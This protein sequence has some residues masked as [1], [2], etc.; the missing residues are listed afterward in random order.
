MLICATERLL[1]LCACC[2]RGNANRRSS[3]KI[4]SWGTM[5]GSNRTTSTSSACCTSRGAR[6]CRFSS[7]AA[8]SFRDV[9]TSGRK[10]RKMGL[11]RCRARIRVRRAL[12]LV[13]RRRLPL[14]MNSRRC[15]KRIKEKLVARH[16]SSSNDDSTLPGNGSRSRW[17]YL[18]V[19]L[20]QSEWR[21]R[22]KATNG[23]CIVLGGKH[24]R[25]SNLPSRCQTTILVIR[26]AGYVL[27]FI[28]CTKRRR[29]S[30]CT[31]WHR[32][33]SSMSYCAGAA[34]QVIVTFTVP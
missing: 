22:S 10:R 2:R 6:G 18:Y 13:A 4:G 29:A 24:C 26:L 8:S 3:G 20:R 33:G 32:A 19:R 17:G 21:N 28:P 9:S 12:M 14:T 23:K 1:P 15:H 5:T 7:W 31:C 34:V 30:Q 11:R 25:S 16:F 27:F